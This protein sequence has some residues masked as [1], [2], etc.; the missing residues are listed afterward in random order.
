MIAGEA[1]ESMKPWYRGFNGS[2][3]SKS[4]SQFTV[5]GNYECLGES[6]VVITE[7]PVGKW[8]ND[9]KATLE[10]WTIGGVS[11]AAA[12]DEAKAVTPFIKDFKENH[13][14]TTVKFTITVDPA[15]FP[16]IYHSL[17]GL[18]KKFKLDGSVATSNMHMFDG[19]AVIRKFES[20]LD[21]LSAF[22]DVRIEHYVSR[23][24]HLLSRMTEEWEKLDN[25][26]RFILAVID[27][28]LV[29][30]NRKK[31]ELLADLAKKGF[32]AFNDKK[33][34]R[35]VQDPESDDDEPDDDTSPT[36]KLEKGYDYLLSM[37]LWS[38][39]MERVQALK[40]QAAE[41]RRELDT[42]LAKTPEDLWN[43]DLDA[44]EL[45]LNDFDQ[46]FAEAELTESQ[47][48]SKAVKNR[49][50]GGGKKAKKGK[51]YD[52]DMS[53]S[54][55][56]EE[57]YD[58]EEE[59]RKKTAKKK[60]AKAPAK[61]V[62][63]PVL[64]EFVAPAVPVGFKIVVPRAVK[65]KDPNAKPA[66][67]RAPTSSA[68]SKAT[69]T[70]TINAD[71]SDDE[72][73]VLSLFERLKLSNSSSS[74][75]SAF[76]AGGGEPSD[77]A[78]KPKPK[79]ATKK[80]PAAKKAAPAKKQTVS[81]DE[82]ELN[83]ES[84][85]EEEDVAPVQRGTPKPRRATAATKSYADYFQRGDDSEEEEEKEEKEEEEAFNEADDDSDAPVPKKKLAAP[86]AAAKKPPVAKKAAPAATAAPVKKAAPAKKVAAKKYDSD[87]DEDED[88]GVSS[89]EESDEEYSD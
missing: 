30:S 8:V 11:M 22:Y 48:R 45:A 70:V 16:E 85:S 77:T 35:D 84:E 68:V 7:L 50:A 49:A 19:N 32:K 60:A 38:L 41:K 89:E 46:V 58:S 14:D 66:A 51:A 53:E 57:D 12:G 20:E 63:E 40:S 27:N 29:V 39:T 76:T 87:E 37:K 86:K 54:E 15:Q 67:K 75:I 78:A 83:S 24:A 82:E 62:K 74:S 9:Y 3:T 18:Q 21:V 36:A 34:K 25:K 79:P 88:E 43:E 73:Q 13:T 65:P 47:A 80:A 71:S 69:T 61:A 33:A 4:T 42:L 17:G 59:S 1:P 44:L 2:V 5:A 81:S 31:H 6:T 52:S 56:E 10:S 26:T 23:R 72:P 55:D 28:K 64:A